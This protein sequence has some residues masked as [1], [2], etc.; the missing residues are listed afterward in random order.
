MTNVSKLPYSV[1]AIRGQAVALVAGNA[2]PPWPRKLRDAVE[3]ILAD[4]KAETELSADSFSA[5]GS[6]NWK[7]QAA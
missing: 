7:D 4:E 1:E 2:H 3:A 5:P 6:S